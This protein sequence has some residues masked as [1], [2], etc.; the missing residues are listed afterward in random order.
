MVETGLLEIV[1]RSDSDWAGDFGNTP[2]CHGIS[3][4]CTKRNDV[5]LEFETDSDQSQFMRSKVLRSQRLRRRIVGTN[6]TL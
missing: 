2:K 4:W 3:L 1:G 5:Q 6:R